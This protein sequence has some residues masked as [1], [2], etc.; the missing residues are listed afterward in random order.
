MGFPNKV[1]L[2][3]SDSTCLEYGTNQKIKKCEYIIIRFA[4]PAKAVR[5]KSK[6]KRKKNVRFS[7]S[8]TKEK[9]DTQIVPVLSKTSAK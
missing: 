5:K 7:R 6:K 9:T 2:L 3:G 4:R 8:L 1:V